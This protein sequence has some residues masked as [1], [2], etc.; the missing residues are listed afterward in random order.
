[1]PMAAGQQRVR[2]EYGGPTLRGSSCWLVSHIPGTF[3]APAHRVT[4]S[5]ARQPMAAQ[6]ASPNDRAGYTYFAFHS[7][8]RAPGN[9]LSFDP[10]YRDRSA[11]NMT[12]TGHRASLSGDA[13]SNTVTHACRT[14]A[15]AFFF[16]GHHI[17][18]ALSC[19]SAAAQA[20]RLTPVVERHIFCWG[21]STALVAGAFLGVCRNGFLSSMAK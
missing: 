17:L 11:T 8:G 12:P 21:H 9:F 15:L 6:P 3:D 1:M 16:H 13:T 2:R 7:G 5:H 10:G 4:C 14:R 19:G 18:L 20:A